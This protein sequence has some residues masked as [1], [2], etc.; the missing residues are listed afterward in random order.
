MG[1]SAIH[2]SPSQFFFF[3]FFFTFYLYF[4]YFFS[5]FIFNGWNL[6]LLFATLNLN[7]PYQLHQVGI[8]L[9]LNPVCRILKSPSIGFNIQNHLLIPHCSYISQVVKRS[10]EWKPLA[11]SKVNAF[12]TAKMM[13][14]LNQKPIYSNQLAS[15]FS[16]SLS[17]Q[18]QQ[19]QQQHTHT[20]KNLDTY[21]HPRFT[22]ILQ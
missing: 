2:L 4:F 11:K 12:L 6:K 13:Q 7:H 22:C 14:L 20:H 21:A 10:T 19:Q 8:A 9:G 5:F 18:Q 17:W 15:F 1:S 16:P 3:F